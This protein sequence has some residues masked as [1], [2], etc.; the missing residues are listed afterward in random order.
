MS[1]ARFWRKIEEWSFLCY[2]PVVGSMA[3]LTKTS[4]LTAEG[5]AISNS[6]SNISS[7]YLY[8]GA[9]NHD[10]WEEVTYLCK[11]MEIRFQVD[12]YS[13]HPDD[14][15]Q[16]KIDVEWGRLWVTWLL[17]NTFKTS[18]D[19][20]VVKGTVAIFL[21]VVNR[22]LSLDDA[23]DMVQDNLLNPSGRGSRYYY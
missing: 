11:K 16:T 20:F 4:G 9:V 10:L 14:R 6:L 22:Y 21:P 7:H 1:R 13:G 18:G 8:P 15:H 2:M 17:L 3:T 12:W 23:L 5:G 19:S